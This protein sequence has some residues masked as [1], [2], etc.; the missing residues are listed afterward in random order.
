MHCVRTQEGDNMMG[1]NLFT[2]IASLN[3]YYEGKIDFDITFR[4][5][6]P[7]AIVSAHTA[8]NINIDIYMSEEKANIIEEAYL[9]ETIDFLI[10]Q[11]KYRR[12]VIKE[13][14]I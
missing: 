13:K 5:I 11:E 1:S 10:E 6:D 2:I 12:K 3:E 9:K 7:E 4:Q 8:E 14:C